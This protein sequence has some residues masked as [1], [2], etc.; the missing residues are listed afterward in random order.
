MPT[1]VRLFLLF[2]FGF[3]AFLGLTLPFVVAQAVEAP[4]TGIGLLWMLLLAYLIFTMTL[5]WQRKQAAFRLALG[6]AT[7]TI[8]LVPLLGLL[9]GLP[10]VLFA[11][12]LSLS[13][14]WALFQPDVRP[15]FVEP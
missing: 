11:L 2:S 4:V 12:G 9:V 7:L 14:F 6:L 3:L 13:V 15:W 10:G 5:V 1:G 8:P